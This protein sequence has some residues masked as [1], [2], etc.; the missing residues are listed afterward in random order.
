[1]D[2]DVVLSEISQDELEWRRQRAY[3]D[4][5]SRI[6]S[7][8]DYAKRRG[9]EEGKADSRKEIAQKMKTNGIEINIIA[10]CTGLSKEE[11]ETL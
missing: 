8:E 11:I 6:A 10:N 2:A 3:Y 4:N 5:I 7:A 1:M 9:F